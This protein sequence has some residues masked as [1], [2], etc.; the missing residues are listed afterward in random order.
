VGKGHGLEERN[1]TFL[2]FHFFTVWI[3]YHEHEFIMRGKSWL[4]KNWRILMIN[5]K[6]FNNFSFFQGSCL[7][8][9]VTFHKVR[10]QCKWYLLIDLKVHYS[11]SSQ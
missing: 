10:Q 4:I 9:P 7:K 2:S 1:F 6:E 8:S 3:I 5:S 11:L